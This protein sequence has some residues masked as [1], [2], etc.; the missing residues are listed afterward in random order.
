MKLQEKRNNIKLGSVVLHPK[1]K[2]ESQAIEGATEERNYELNQESTGSGQEF[3]DKVKNVYEKVAFA[4]GFGS[5]TEFYD[6]DGLVIMTTDVQED[7]TIVFD[8]GD[9]SHYTYDKSA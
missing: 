3:R 4:E 2:V 9:G 1:I 6:E 8:F 5:W 7:G